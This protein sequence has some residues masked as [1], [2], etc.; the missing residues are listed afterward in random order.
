MNFE[1][2][3]LGGGVLLV[4]AVVFLLKA[5]TAHACPI[6]PG[7]LLRQCL[8]SQVRGAVVTS[9]SLTS[10]GWTSRTAATPSAPARP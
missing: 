7:D 1:F 6:V 5:V 10:C 4:L 9:A 2:G 8:W 3:W